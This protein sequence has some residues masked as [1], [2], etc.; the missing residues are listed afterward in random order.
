MPEVLWDEAAIR[1]LDQ[2]WDHIGRENQNPTAADRFIDSIRD[3]SH[4]YARQPLMGTAWPEFAPGV[5]LS[6][7]AIM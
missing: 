7:L 1:D 5:R 4:A 3:R 6:L 2:I